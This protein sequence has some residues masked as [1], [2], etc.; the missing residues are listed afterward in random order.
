MKIISILLFAQLVLCAKVV[1]VLVALHRVAP[2][3]KSEIS[4][5][6]SVIHNV[7]SVTNMIKKLVTKCSSDEYIIIN[8]PGLLFEDISDE[9]MDNWRFIRR[10][11]MLALTVVGLPRV[12]EPLDLDF[13]EQYI[14]KSCDAEVINVH[15]DDDDGAVEYYDTR[16]RIIRIDLMELPKDEEQ[17]WFMMHEHDELVRSIIRKLPSPHYT[18]IFTSD[19]PTNFHPTPPSI[20]E[21]FPDKFEIF[22]NIV[23]DPLRKEEVERNNNFRKVDPTWIENKNT[24]LRY[25]RNKKQH[26]IHLTDL[27]LWE[28]YEKLVATIVLMVASLFAVKTIN[29][30]K[31]LRS[32]TTRKIQSRKKERKNGIILRKED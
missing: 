6:N 9:H 1:P 12:E 15:E 25:L 31:T 2:G 20:I 24:N 3:L 13:L 23:N 22:N 14:I 21:S 16:T 32:W 7:T 28:K 18:L 10:Y 30:V 27:P 26:E 4:P 8:Q 5:Q 11:A 29:A 19:T 17:R